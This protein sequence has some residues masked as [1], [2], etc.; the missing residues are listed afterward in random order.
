MCNVDV[1]Q[2][3]ALLRRDTVLYRTCPRMFAPRPAGHW[4]RAGY[5]RHTS[6]RHKIGAVYQSISVA[7]AESVWR[8]V[9][10]NTG[11]KTHAIGLFAC[12]CSCINYAA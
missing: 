11:A 8:H 3:L 2:V 12:G 7:S 4:M 6:G 1:L 9:Q 5:L 10:R